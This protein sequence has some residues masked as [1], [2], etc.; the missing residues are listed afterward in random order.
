MYHTVRA[1]IGVTLTAAF[2][3]GL[4]I[5]AVVVGDVV[6]DAVLA[7]GHS[8]T[9]QSRR[10]ALQACALDATIANSFTREEKRKATEAGFEESRHSFRWI[11]DT[12]GKAS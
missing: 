6:I 11:G 2:A 4:A 3:S 7:D 9:R 8:W 10:G 5:G 12:L 1:G